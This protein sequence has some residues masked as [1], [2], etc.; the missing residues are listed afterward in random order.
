MRTCENHRKYEKQKNMDN[1]RKPLD[2][3]SK[4]I[5]SGSPLSTATKTKEKQKGPENNEKM[6][7]GTRKAGPTI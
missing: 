5:V 6:Q 3:Q 1:Y 7:L 2:F 4:N